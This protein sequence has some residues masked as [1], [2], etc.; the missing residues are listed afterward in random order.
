MKK[1]YFAAISAALL[2]LAAACSNEAVEPANQATVQFSVNL[3]D[4][5]SRAISDG[6]TV[7]QLI[8]AVYDNEGNELTDLRQKD[9][10]ITGRQAQVTTTVARG[11]KYTFVF[12]AQK[13]G[14]DYYNTTNLKDVVVS[15]DGP[16]NDETRDAFTNVYEVEKVTGPINETV[17]LYRPFAQLDYVCDLEEWTDLV[18]SNYKLVGSDLLVKAGAFTHLNLLTGE[19]SQPTTE[20]FTLS[21]SNYYKEHQ[22][23]GEFCGFVTTKDNTYQDLF[24]SQDGDKFWISMNYLLASKQQTVLE[25]AE[26]NI[27]ALVNNS[28]K[29]VK[30]ALDNIPIQ[31]NHRTVVYVSDLTKTVTTVIKIDPNFSGDIND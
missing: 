22:S 27:Y 20:E 6:T 4:I 12:W 5:Q 11:Q 2:M 1:I 29:P 26:M 3:D 19:V 15:Y 21:M 10:T 7:D 24:P 28:P 31:R 25:H 18:N 23:I 14:N 16:A 30:I 13:S 8:F 9:V 17:T